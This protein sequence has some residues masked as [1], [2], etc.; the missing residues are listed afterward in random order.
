MPSYDSHKIEIEKLKVVE[1]KRIATSLES[2]KRKVVALE[3]IA[4]STEKIWVML[5]IITGF[6]SMALFN[7]LGNLNPLFKNWVS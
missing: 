4:K 7:Y 6:V 1:L 2:E 5:V 3:S